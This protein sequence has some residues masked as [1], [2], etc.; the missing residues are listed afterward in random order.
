M[1]IQRIITLSLDKCS[2]TKQPKL[3]FGRLR[4][5]STCIWHKYKVMTAMFEDTCDKLQVRKMT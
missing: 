1:T 2:N 3:Q 5:I 4:F